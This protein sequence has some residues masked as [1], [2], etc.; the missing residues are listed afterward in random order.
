MWT[1]PKTGKGWTDD[2]E[3]AFAQIEQVSRLNRIQAI[4]LW[5]RCGKDL[6]K[7]LQI[8]KQNYPP[9]TAAQL[10]GL[11]KARKARKARK[12]VQGSP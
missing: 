4:Q 3:A 8:A 12:T 7:A 1:N 9:A 6:A 11:A 2:E 10:A 5:K